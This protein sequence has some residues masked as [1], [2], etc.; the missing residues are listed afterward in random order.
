MSGHF[1]N[2]AQWLDVPVSAL[3]NPT[4]AQ[5][6]YLI[7]TFLLVTDPDS[8][9]RVPL[10]PNEMQRHI[11]ET[12]CDYEISVKW[13]RAGLTTI[14]CARAWIKLLLQPSISV[15]L[16]AHNDKTARD[17][18]EQV[19][20][21]QYESIP[22]EIR[23]PADRSTVNSLYFKELGSKFIVRTAGQSETSARNAGQ[24]RTINVL[25]LTE[26][27][28]YRYAETL[29]QS[30]INCVPKV[31]GC[32]WIDSTPEGQN[33]FYRRFM[34]AKA[35]NSQYRARFYPWWWSER[36]MLDTQDF[37]LEELTEEEEEL[38]EGNPHW[39]DRRGPDK[40][41][42]EQL[43]WRRWKMN[44]IEPLGN[45]T[46]QDRFRVEF[47]EDDASCFLHSGRPVFM[48]NVLV[49]KGKLREAI[50]GHEHVIGQDTSTGSATGHP[51]GIV[52][53]D[54][55]TTPAEQVYEWIGH[56]PTDVQ[57]EKVV[58]LQKRYPGQI[59]VERNFPGEA[60]L[61]LL[62]RWDIDDVYQHRDWELKEGGKRVATRKPGFPTT[63]IT[64]PR[65]FTELDMS[66]NRKEL[67]LSGPFTISDLKGMAYN[68][69][70]KIEFLGNPDADPWRGMNSHGEL[71][72]AIALAWH[73]RK[74]AILPIA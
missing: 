70:D 34:K 4:A 11:V 53:I 23:P 47:P 42:P 71:A 39:D 68:D 44:D 5:M 7:E 22:E 16:F 48:P 13:R 58:E 67:I 41:T 65:V 37:D 61:Q 54:I 26:F 52:V 72:I 74:S 36:C 19:V 27:A 46:T 59:V 24:A 69:D 56:A 20:L 1:E 29:M 9:K 60:I 17:I 40:L 33:S 50:P 64:K 32:I 15:E 8:G 6:V 3:S 25:I 14:Y 55:T 66:L 62:R 10:I 21:P 31:G 73:G 35:G 2:V 51:A 63:G 12:A 38:G 43:A 18:F 45:L 57:A 28:L 30:I 49:S